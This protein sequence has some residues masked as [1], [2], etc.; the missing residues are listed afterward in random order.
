M[1]QAILVTRL[2]LLLT[3]MLLAGRAAGTPGAQ[4]PHW[5]GA[6][7]QEVLVQR[8]HSHGSVCLHCC[9]AV[10]SGPCTVQGF[11]G[12]ALSVKCKYKQ[13]YE[14]KPKFWCKKGTGSHCAAD[15]IITSKNHPV[16][17]QD[18]LSIQDN[19]A[20]R[21]FTVTMEALTEG[22]AGN[23]LCGVRT[24][25]TQSNESVN[26]KVIVSPAPTLRPGPAIPPTTAA[27]PGTPDPFRYFPVL[28]GLQVLALLAMSGAVLWVSL[29][30]G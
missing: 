16:V 12:G 13:R 21:K 10:V 5:T 11:L 6:M 17:L 25:K 28:A 22:D 23:Y 26:V 7:G 24:G 3:W 8:Q 2:L 9:C 18:R 30:G 1:A 20:Q 29:R 27:P 19:R 14:R 15:I 4:A